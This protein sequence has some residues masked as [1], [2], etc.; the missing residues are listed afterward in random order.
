L[1]LGYT[2]FKLVEGVSV[3]QIY[4]GRIAMDRSG[5]HFENSP[6]L[7]TGPFGEDLD[8][9]WQD[10]MALSRTISRVGWGWIDIHAAA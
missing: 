7:S 9:P 4:G 10:V 6:P 1:D 8:G 3:S 5:G 2:R